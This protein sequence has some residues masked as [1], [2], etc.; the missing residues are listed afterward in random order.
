MEFS[1][2]WAVLTA[3]ALCWLGLKIWDERLPEHA[4]DRLIAAAIAGLVLGRVVAMLIQGINPL[5]NPAELVIVRGGVDTVAAT[6]GFVLTLTWSTRTRPG[7]MDAMAPA[8]LLG[9][10]GWHAG[11]IWREACLGTPSDL[12]W[13]WAQP[14]GAVSRHP[15]E[16]YAALGL[17]LA[18]YAI[19]RLGWRLWLRAGAG[20]AA[21]SGIR[22]LTEPLRPSLGGGRIWWYV[23]GVAVGAL[24]VLWAPGS[25]RARST[26][27]T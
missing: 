8:I 9:L 12:M 15:V 20:L 4:G 23:A 25:S 26:A 6:I 1:L 16:V 22:L 18:A 27:P 11:C 21:A 14:G 17:A 24:L 3:A 19:S 7:A 13:A 10:A 5:T 2:L